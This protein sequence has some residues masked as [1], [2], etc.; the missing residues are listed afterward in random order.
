MVDKDVI[1][2]CREFI[3]ANEAAAEE[4]LSRYFVIKEYSLRELGATALSEFL[5][6]SVEDIEKTP[7]ISYSKTMQLPPIV[8][9]QPPE[10]VVH[11]SWLKIPE[12]L[13]NL[14][15]YRLAPRVFVTRPAAK[16][17]EEPSENL[18][19]EEYTMSV[20]PVFHL[21]SF[22][23]LMHRRFPLTEKCIGEY[24][25]KKSLKE[26]EKKKSLEELQQLA[27]ANSKAAARVAAQ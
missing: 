4:Y 16:F 21:S 8:P 15:C 13:S 5:Y 22:V 1:D 6:M 2:E 18:K 10:E 12:H 11:L 23:S 19:T 27:T 26:Y 3:A 20:L 24:E 25:K 9:K 7:G 14:R 17:S